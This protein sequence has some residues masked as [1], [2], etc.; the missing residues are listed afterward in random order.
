VSSPITCWELEKRE[1][2]YRRGCKSAGVGSGLRRHRQGIG[3]GDTN[4]EHG[5][6]EKAQ[7]KKQ[8]NEGYTLLEPAMKVDIRFHAS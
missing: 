7:G 2:L 8:K 6:R 5:G 3:G 1:V 4:A